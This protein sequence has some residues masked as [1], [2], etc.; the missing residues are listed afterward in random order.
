[1]QIILSDTNPGVV[2]G[3]R[4]YFKD[5]PDVTIFPGS[6]FETGCNTIV[7]PAN[8]F[9]F[10]DGGLDLALSHYLGWHVQERVQAKIRQKLHGELLV[11]QAEIVETDHPQIPYLISAPTMRVPMILTGTVNVYLAMRAILLLIKHGRLEDQTPI[12]EVVSR[13]AVSGLGTGVGK[14]PAEIC[15]KQMRAAYDEVILEK[16]FFP[17]SWAQA[18]RNH[19]L[20]YA[21]RARDLQ[22]YQ[23]LDWEDNA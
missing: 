21:Q 2:Q 15:A 14:V 23:N 7:S 6:I 10:M 4:H 22:Y 19:Q 17:A 13:V 16:E 5:C 3:W 8:S 9:G 18:Q 11:G 12:R 20:L 1:M